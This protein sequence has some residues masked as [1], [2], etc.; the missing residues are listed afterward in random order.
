[1]TFVN[2]GLLHKALALQVEATESTRDKHVGGVLL[3]HMRAQLQYWVQ[4][5]KPW[6]SVLEWKAALSL[7]HI[8]EIVNL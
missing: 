1:M 6:A 5:I 8:P 4:R 7:A 3:N 2:I